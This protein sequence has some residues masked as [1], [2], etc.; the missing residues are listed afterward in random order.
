MKLLSMLRELKTQII[1]CLISICLQFNSS[2][3][4]NHRICHVRHLPATATIGSDTDSICPPPFI[5]DTEL[6]HKAFLIL[7]QLLQ[8]LEGLLLDPG[9]V[10]RCVSSDGGIE[11]TATSN[12]HANQS[13]QPPCRHGLSRHIAQL[14]QTIQISTSTQTSHTIIIV[15]KQH[16]P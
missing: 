7:R 8:P 2:S 12:A 11:P 5:L 16:L 6:R 4:C 3:H 9:S 10:E 13:G 15:H 1:S 14:L